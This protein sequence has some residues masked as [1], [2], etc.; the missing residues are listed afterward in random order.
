M[1]NNTSPIGKTTREEGERR[2]ALFRSSGGVTKED[3]SKGT[4]RT[5]G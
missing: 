1:I 2:G 5:R 3:L 4:K